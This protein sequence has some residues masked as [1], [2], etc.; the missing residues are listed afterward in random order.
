[1]RLLFVM[2]SYLKRRGAYEWRSHSGGD[3]SSVRY[4]NIRFVLE[5]EGER[6]WA[7]WSEIARAKGW[8]L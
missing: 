7:L 1:M 6:F 4:G 3:G 2:G 5:V 8:P